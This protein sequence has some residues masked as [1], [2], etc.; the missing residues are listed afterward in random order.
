MASSPAAASA[1]PAN[2]FDQ[3]ISWCRSLIEPSI[4]LST[5]LEELN[6]ATGA[7]VK[8]ALVK[9]TPESYRS[10]GLILLADRVDY[11]GGPNNLETKSITPSLR[12][13]IKNYIDFFQSKFLN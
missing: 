4:N 8:A 5:F 7:L 10:N 11:S 12:I 2:F 13:A 6:T 3:A 1:A 9:Y